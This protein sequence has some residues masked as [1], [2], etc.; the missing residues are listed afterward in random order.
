MAVHIWKGHAHD[1]LKIKNIKMTTNVLNGCDLW[2]ICP[3]QSAYLLILRLI[4]IDHIDQH[5]F[6]PCGQ[7]VVNKKHEPVFGGMI[8]KYLYNDGFAFDLQ[9]LFPVLL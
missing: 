9:P 6:V 7:I 3:R 4:F 5:V 1:D 8:V 2:V